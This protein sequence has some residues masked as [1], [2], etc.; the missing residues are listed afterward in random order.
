ME[1]SRVQ[2][3]NVFKAS[4]DRRYVCEGLI[5]ISD[6]NTYCVVYCCLGMQLLFNSLNVSVAK[7]KPLFC[8]HSSLLS[9]CN[10]LSPKH[11]DFKAMFLPVDM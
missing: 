7:V 5:Y 4:N 6:Q 9:I 1:V 3:L 10:T 11:V 2:V 8:R